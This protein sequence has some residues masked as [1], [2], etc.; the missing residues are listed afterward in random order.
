MRERER[1][2]EIK[3]EEKKQENV[4]KNKTALSHMSLRLL[5]YT[6]NFIRKDLY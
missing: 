2:E 3:K 6:Y 4:K 5:R 1:E